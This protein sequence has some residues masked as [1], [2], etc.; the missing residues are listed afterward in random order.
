[1]PITERGNKMTPLQPRI[2]AMF[3]RLEW[4]GVAGQCDYDCPDT[5]PEPKCPICGNLERRGHDPDC[6][7]AALIA[8]LEAE[9]PS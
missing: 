9:R 1:M 4:S 8:E 7:L 5:D 3:R 2:L 6:E